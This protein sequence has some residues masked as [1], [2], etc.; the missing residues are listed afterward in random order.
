MNARLA[1]PIL[2]NLV[3]SGAFER[4]MGFLQ[5]TIGCLGVPRRNGSDVGLQDMGDD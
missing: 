2:G 1:K 3:Y 4:L 5:R